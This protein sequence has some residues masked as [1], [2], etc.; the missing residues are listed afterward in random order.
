MAT[1]PA[2]H[3]S[4]LPLEEMTI[5]PKSITF[6]SKEYKSPDM[7]FDF[8]CDN[9]NTPFSRKTRLTEFP[10]TV[11]CP[12]CGDID[13]K[14]SDLLNMGWKT[15]PSDHITTVKTKES[16][17]CL[18]CGNVAK[19]QQ[20]LPAKWKTVKKSKTVGK[21]GCMFCHNNETIDNRSNEYQKDIIKMESY[22]FKLI[23]KNQY[24]DME[25]QCL[26]CNE[27]IPKNLYYFQTTGNMVCTKCGQ[28]HTNESKKI[29]N[30]INREIS[31]REKSITSLSDKNITVIDD[32][33]DNKI[34]VSCNICNLHFAH[35]LDYLKN[36]AIPCPK[37]SKETHSNIVKVSRLNGTKDAML[38]R[39]EKSSFKLCSKEYLGINV[40]QDV[41]CKYCGTI[42][43]AVPKAILQ[44]F[45]KRS[46]SLSCPKCLAE[47]NDNK[48]G[49]TAQKYVDIIKS[50]GEYEILT[51]APYPE[52]E[53]EIKVLRKTCNHTFSARITNLKTR[54]TICPECN[55]SN[56]VQ[57]LQEIHAIKYAEY[58]KSLPAKESYARDVWKFTRLSKKNYMHLIN[59]ENHPMTKAGGD[60]YQ[61]DHILSIKHCFDNNIPADVCGSYKNLRTILA[62]ENNSKSARLVMD[63]PAELLQHVSDDQLVKLFRD[64]MVK[65]KYAALV[66]PHIVYFKNVDRYINLLP[67]E[68]ISQKSLVDIHDR[69]ANCYSFLQDEW[70]NNMVSIYNKIKYLTNQSDSIKIHARNCI[71]D[72]ITYD[73]VKDFINAYHIQKN[74]KAYKKIYGAFYNGELVAVM[75]FGIPR[76]SVS[77]NPDEYELLRFCTHDDYNIPGIGSKLLTYF[78]RNNCYSKIIT[79]ANKRFSNGNLYKQ[80]GFELESDN[81]TGYWYIKEGHKF[82][83]YMCTKALLVEKFGKEFEH[84]TESEIMKTLEFQK[85]D[86]IGQYRYVLYNPSLNNL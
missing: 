29:Q 9:C 33:D 32:S 36:H 64:E 61:I 42:Y 51:P 58:V 12:S 67:F 74:V 71:I 72:E 81:D 2:N 13:S 43:N 69:Y 86:D 14:I 41:E 68:N 83:R 15:L 19:A 8:N 5:I 37:C 80:L 52:R 47:R 11:L 56:K 3:K 49:N 6:I 46:D 23:N 77:N 18:D 70:K 45:E 16:Y 76:Y 53:M 24:S 55:N 60:G 26:S 63:T 21:N 44:N 82:S 4:L 7:H 50:F 28:G 25:F 79:Y 30:N 39:I 75:S 1:L 27:H 35:S 62:S 10:I 22:G 85:L 73:E 38:A 78:M 31:N 40:K 34:Q 65:L 59:P 66:T 57:R 48:R 20:D 84:M 54:Q 17:E